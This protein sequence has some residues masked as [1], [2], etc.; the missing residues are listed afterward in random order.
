MEIVLHLLITF[1]LSLIG[2]VVGG[3]YLIYRRV[4]TP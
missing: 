3:Y 2:L 4:T 1:P